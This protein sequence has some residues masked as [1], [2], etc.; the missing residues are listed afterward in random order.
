MM[1]VEQFQ[2]E[3]LYHAMMSIAKSMLKLIELHRGNYSPLYRNHKVT[4]YG[5]NLLDRFRK[6]GF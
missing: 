3:K 1:S 5:D 6:R 4:V 2:R